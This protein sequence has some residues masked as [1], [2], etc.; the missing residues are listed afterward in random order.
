[1]NGIELCRYFYQE[2][3]RPLLDQHFP[4]LPHTAALI[5]SGSDVMGFDDGMS[6]DH[7]WGP[8][9]LLFLRAAEATQSASLL[10]AM[11][12]HN[13]PAT[14][15]GYSTNFSPP[16]P[17]DNGTQQLQVVESGPINHRVAIDTLQGFF[18][19]YVGLDLT[20]P[21]QP[22][23]WLTLPQQ[24]LRAITAGAVYYDAL[25][26]QQVRER[27]TW[28]PHDVW[29]YLLACGWA[30][31]GQEEHLM[32]RAGL[33][34]DEVGSALLGA[35]LVRDVMRLCLLMER[36]YA[37]YPKWFGTA[38]KQL[39]CADKLYPILQ[40][41]L[42]A[43]TWPEREHH[44]IPAYATLAAM[45][46]ALQLTA[47]LPTQTKQFF[48]RP[49]QVIALHGFAEALLQ[50]IRDPAVQQI[51][52]Q[53]PIGSIDQFSDNTDLLEDS[54]RRPVLRKLYQ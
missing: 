35:R 44:L 26:L 22:A 49:F 16:D 1:M 17:T 21:C 23:D 43:R 45:H 8:R 41:V 27:F 52:Q 36:S 42:A 12:A 54:G 24:K 25:G 7:D 40:E 30:R 32:G 39:P 37:P 9:L 6:T 15:G 4:N 29:L 38:F 2:A 14:F 10:S 28:F 19:D 48:G 31:I 51:A 20:Q 53:R 3:V 50:Q 33:V 47:P 46:N 13:L 11:L 34:G 5:G 18:S